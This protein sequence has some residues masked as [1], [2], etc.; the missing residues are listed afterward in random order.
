MVKDILP[1]HSSSTNPRNFVSMGGNLYFTAD[2]GIHGEELWRT[3]GTLGGT[4]MVKD[5]TPPEGIYFWWTSNNKILGRALARSL[6]AITKC[7]SM[8]VGISDPVGGASRHRW[9][10]VRYENGNRPIPNVSE[11]F[12]PQFGVDYSGVNSIMVIPS[13]VWGF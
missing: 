3:D 4:Y 8:H 9:N 10:R 6:Q 7:S 2:D 12:I 1:R 5:I 13:S 11:S